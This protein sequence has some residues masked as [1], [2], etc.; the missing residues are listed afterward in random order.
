MASLLMSSLK[1]SIICSSGKY[2]VERYDSNPEL[3][4][5]RQALF[6]LRLDALAALSEEF[7]NKARNMSEHERNIFT[8]YVT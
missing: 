7:R 2:R 5:R 3:A 8:M 6:K 4:E 1:V